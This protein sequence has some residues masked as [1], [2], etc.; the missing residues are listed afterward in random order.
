MNQDARNEQARRMAE[1][2]ISQ[3]EIIAL[4]H[5][6]DSE[7]YDNSQTTKFAYAAIAA[8]LVKLTEGQEPVEYQLLVLGSRWAHCSKQL[9]ENSQDRSVVRA[10]YTL[11]IP[12]QQ[13]GRV[14]ENAAPELLAIA[15]KL[16]L[17]TDEGDDQAQGTHYVDKQGVIRCKGSFLTLIEEARAAIDA[18][19]NKEQGK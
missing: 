15:E 17:A 18:A 13:E 1:E 8:A 19:R 7:A 5:D 3:E 16:A 11:P 14:R 12:S 10:L 6:V 2:L 9:Y 4:A